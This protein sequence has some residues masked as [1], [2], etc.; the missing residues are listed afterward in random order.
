MRVSECKEY[1]R[2]WTSI[3]ERAKR[4]TNDE[5]ALDGVSEEEA[6]EIFDAV[7]CGDY[8]DMLVNAIKR[9]EAKT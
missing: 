9:I 8:N 6:A 5:L 4:A 7:E 2:I 3:E 1:I